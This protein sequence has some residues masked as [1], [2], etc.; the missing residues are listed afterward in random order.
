MTFFLP[1]SFPMQGFVEAVAAIVGC[2][3][4]A[5]ASIKVQARSPVGSK[6]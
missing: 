2:R 5:H 1:F 3:T 6:S 4:S